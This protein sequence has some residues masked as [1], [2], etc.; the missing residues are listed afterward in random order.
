M[1]EAMASTCATG[2]G[3]RSMKKSNFQ[4]PST[5]GLVTWRFTPAGGVDAHCSVFGLAPSSG[6]GPPWLSMP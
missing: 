2:V 4:A 1:S 6:F 3:I 5:S